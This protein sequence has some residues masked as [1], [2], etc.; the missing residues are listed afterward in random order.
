VV[1]N[2]P[3]RPVS[4]DKLIPGLTHYP[5]L[6]ADHLPTPEALSPFD[7]VGPVSSTSEHKTGDEGAKS[8]DDVDEGDDSPRGQTA[9]SPRDPAEMTESPREL[10]DGVK[11][12]DI[13]P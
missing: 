7:A 6:F 3:P 10:I 13:V 12:I 4:T 5:G 11:G 8:D 1:I 9:D 2:Q